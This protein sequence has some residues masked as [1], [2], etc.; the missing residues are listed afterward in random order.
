MG[1]HFVPLQPLQQLCFRP[2]C[3]TGVHFLRHRCELLTTVDQSEP[4]SFKCTMKTK[5][6]AL[7][8][9]I[10]WTCGQ[11]GKERRVHET[12]NGRHGE[13]Y[14]TALHRGLED[15]G[16]PQG[17]LCPSVTHFLFT[18]AQEHYRG[19]HEST[20]SLAK[21]IIIRQDRDS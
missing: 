5:I 17:A 4:I 14:Q 19:T 6:P 21:A 11:P 8:R 7:V 16:Y 9:S 12:G 18:F 2:P 13:I 3:C 15:T 20:S 1:S 10:C